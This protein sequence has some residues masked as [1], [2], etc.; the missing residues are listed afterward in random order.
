ME[1]RTREKPARGREQ[2]RERDQ[3]DL[4]EKRWYDREPLAVFVPLSVVGAAA[5]Q[6]VAYAGYKLFYNSFGVRPEE[7]GYDY[8]SLFPRTAMQ[9]AILVSVALV[10]LAALSIAVA[11]YGAIGVGFLRGQRESKLA[12]PAVEDRRA[13][14]L[15]FGIAAVFAVTLVA[16]AIG[17]PSIAFYAFATVV[18]LSL[19]AEHIVARDTK[20]RS[21]LDD[22]FRPRIYRAPRRILLIAAAL[23]LPTLDATVLPL[24]TAEVVIWTIAIFLVDRAVPVVQKRDDARIPGGGTSR[25]LR[26]TGVLALSGAVA[27][28][29]LSLLAAAIAWSG[30]PDRVT[31]VRSG[32]ALR[33]N[34]SQPFDLVV[35][36]AEPRAER[37]LVRWIGAAS[38]PP[39]FR[40]GIE[41]LAL[42]YFG[43]ANGVSVFLEPQAPGT[44][45]GR[46][47]RWPTAAV[48]LESDDP[49]DVPS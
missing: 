38:P 34:F 32:H 27:S 7:V 21:W 14:F 43:Q 13:R 35:V 31:E 17:L 28:V 42:T 49:G 16:S 44:G 45:P 24:S 3:R 46:V 20:T 10:V 33:H 37:V 30:L 2:H 9:I 1:R 23:S 5:L 47:Y 8:A 18:V 39:P 15:G 40:K 19:A 26:G 36:L 6:T 41:L 48:A 22:L 25:W 4:P 12:D 11:F 29:A